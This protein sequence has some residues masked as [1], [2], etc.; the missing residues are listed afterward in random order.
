MEAATARELVEFVHRL[1]PTRPVSCGVQQVGP[2]KDEV[3]S[4]LDVAGYNDGGGACFAYEQDHQKHPERV[5]VATEAPHTFQTR[6]FYRTMTWWRDKN[7]PRIEIPNLTEE[8]LFFDGALQYNSSYD[9]SGV[10][11]SARHSLGFVEK[12]PFLI[13]EFRWTGFDYLGESFG[14]PARS[15]NFGIIDLAN[16]PKDHYYFYQSRFT[17]SPM[18]HLLPHWTHP[19][20]EGTAIPVWVYTNCE[21]AELLLNGRSLGRKRMG[22]EMY[23]SWD[24][25]Y[26][27]GTLKA[28]GYRDGSTAAEKQHETS[29]EPAGIRLAADNTE[30]QPDGRDLTQVS[31][32]IVDAD[33]RLVPSGDNAVAFHITGPAVLLGTENGD[34]LDLTPAQSPVRKAF[35]GLGMGLIQ[36]TREEGPIE[37]M[38]AVIAGQSVFEQSA[39]VCI[40]L[41]RIELRSGGSPTKSFSIYYTT[42]GSEPH[43]GAMMYTA[44]FRIE[45]TCRVRAAV[46]LEGKVVLLLQAD[47]RRGVREKVIDST[48]G[49][50]QTDMT[51]KFP[52]PFAEQICGVW[53]DGVKRY[54]FRPDGTA[55]HSI[56]KETPM[57]FG[58]WWYDYPADPFE[59]PDYS[60]SGELRLEEGNKLAALSLSSQKAERLHIQLSNRVLVLERDSS[61]AASCI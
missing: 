38:A 57:P 43:V 50:L 10:R 12:Y 13:G 22:E 47:F 54:E 25:P 49:N 60:G 33:G 5:M 29:G 52:G 56:G 39:T 28:V 20:L 23:L 9:N 51:D 2:D 16:F 26:E 53:T 21:E 4:I 40:S 19:G 24:V 3:R 15:A 1:D 45:Q 14:W 37:V 46:A 8:E 61:Q 7:R 42:D 55:V 48:H 30:L 32:S 34:P 44:P 31:Y 27:P 41:E 36:S 59:T 11:T 6:G 18:V 17:R 35:Y 58:A